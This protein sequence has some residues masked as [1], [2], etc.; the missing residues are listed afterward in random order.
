MGGTAIVIPSL[1][2]FFMSSSHTGCHFP[3]FGILSSVEPGYVL[4]CDGFLILRGSLGI[5]VVKAVLLFYA[6]LQVRAGANAAALD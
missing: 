1:D 4:F 3:P 6:A 5:V 2:S